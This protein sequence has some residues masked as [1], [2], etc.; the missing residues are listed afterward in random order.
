MGV[1][2]EYEKFIELDKSEINSIIRLSEP[3][4]SASIDEYGKSF[5]FHCDGDKVVI[6]YSNKPYFLR[7]SVGNTSGSS[8]SDFFVSV[9]LLRKVLSSC[10]ERLV[11]VEGEESFGFEILGGVMY[12]ETLSSLSAEYYEFDFPDTTNELDMQSARVCFNDMSKVVALSTRSSEKVIALKDGYAFFNSTFFSAKMKSPFVGGEEFVVF[13][14]VG[15][16]LGVLTDICKSVTYSLSG[17][18]LVL[19]DGNIQC[20]V[21]IGLKVDDFYSPAVDTLLN[22]DA[23]VT[24]NHSNLVNLVNLVNGLDY[25]CDIL[26]Y[27]FGEKEL[28]I[29]VY[30]RS[31]E[32]KS[33]YKFPYL[34]G[35]TEKGEVYLSS[36]VMKVVYSYMSDASKYALT[37]DGICVSISDDCKFVIHPMQR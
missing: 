20:S 23:N 15:N 7:C 8:V 5:F 16:F 27:K 19:T 17:N 31:F 22:F 2:K 24:F 35:T 29:T 30:S 1:V 4:V 3:L 28:S 33:V 36:K 32:N 11:I 6:S 21:P 34:T 25:L 37:Q 18:T 26:T 10:G 9:S 14:V 12:L 13:L